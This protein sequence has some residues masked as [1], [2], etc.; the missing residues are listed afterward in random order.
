MTAPDSA[1]LRGP[2]LAAVDG[3]E[4]STR[5]AA[6]AADL[7]RRTGA[8]LHLVHVV[9]EPAAEWGTPVEALLVFR[10]RRANRV[11]HDH[12]D[13]VRALGCEVTEAHLP[14][15]SPVDEVLD[16]AAQI[17]AALVVV[18]SRGRSRSRHMPMGSVAEGVV[19]HG[20]QPT[21]VLRGPGSWP[22]RQ[23]V[24][25]DDASGDACHAG[26]LAAEIALAY[27]VRLVVVRAAPLL[28]EVLEEGAEV[29]QAT[30][31]HLR[32]EA[33]AGLERRAAA[34]EARMGVRPAVRLVVDDPATALLDSALEGGES[35]LVAVGSRGLGP[36]QRLRLGSVS[37]KVLRG[38]PGAVLVVP[39]PRR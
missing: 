32:Q 22:P 11:L 25:G 33:E 31:G 1:R 24:L 39:S 37:T 18:G 13:D 36:M 26:L 4:D 38:A 3:S 29:D 2:I 14:S 7:A 10:A 27:D 20:P 9:R 35:T 5:A 34:V 6:A 30:I 15:G 21:L 16:V 17:D 8:P 12:V 19:H 28:E 23:V